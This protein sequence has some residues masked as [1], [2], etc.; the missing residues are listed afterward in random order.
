MSEQ[1][2]FERR[3]QNDRRQNDRDGK[4]D[5]RRNRCAL[6]LHYAPQSEV[7]GMCQ[8]HQKLIRAQD[9]ACVYYAETPTPGG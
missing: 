5:R 8:K 3:R 7:G 6:C 1:I 2:G 4:Y 9:F